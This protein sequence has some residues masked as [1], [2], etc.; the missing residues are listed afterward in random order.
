M[1]QIRIHDFRHSCATWL[2]S[3]GTPITVISKI[4]R[5]ANTNETLKTYTHLVEDDYQNQL[6][7]LNNLK[8]QVQKQVQNVFEQ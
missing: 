7:K 6:K 1:K 5:H 4:M 2:Y 8:K 3:I